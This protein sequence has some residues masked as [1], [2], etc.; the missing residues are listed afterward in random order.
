MNNKI[1]WCACLLIC[2]FLLLS[3]S[4]WNDCFLSSFR[5][6][7]PSNGIWRLPVNGDHPTILATLIRIFIQLLI[8]APLHDLCRRY[9]DRMELIVLVELLLLLLL[10]FCYFYFYLLLIGK[11]IWFFEEKR[12]Q[13]S[14]FLP[15][16]SLSHFHLDHSESFLSSS[17]FFSSISTHYSCRYSMASSSSAYHTRSTSHMHEAAPGTTASSI[18]IERRNQ[19]EPSPPGGTAMSETQPRHFCIALTN[20]PRMLRRADP[21][22]HDVATVMPTSSVSVSGK[23]EKC[24]PIS[25]EYDLDSSTY[26]IGPAAVDLTVAITYPP[27][28]FDI[29]GP[30]WTTTTTT[31]TSIHTTKARFDDSVGLSGLWTENWRRFQS[32]SP[33]IPANLFE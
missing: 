8:V 4:Y 1:K 26:S 12:A 3:I 25:L 28:T 13:R 31:R 29:S 17:H 27:I 32:S 19:T 33:T 20:N 15:C 16:S 21:A 2:F 11:R 14:P 9:N 18:T 6:M 24:N 10:L 30:K 22:L 7:L 5:R 23:R